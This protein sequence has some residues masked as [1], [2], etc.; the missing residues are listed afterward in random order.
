MGNTDRAIAIRNNGISMYIR[1]LVVDFEHFSRIG[2]VIDRHSFISNHRHPANFTRMEPA[3][4]YMSC[5]VIGKSEVKMCDI[6]DARLKMGMSLYFDL[7]RLFAKYIEQ[8]RYIM[9]GKIPDDID[10]TTKQA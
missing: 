9:R 6:V 5:H 8:D 1:S 10:I 2:I 4:V 7:I 3:Y